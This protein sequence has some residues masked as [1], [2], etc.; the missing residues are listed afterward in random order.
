[1]ALAASAS[2]IFSFSGFTAHVFLFSGGV[3]NCVHQEEE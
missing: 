3:L 2:G 1:M